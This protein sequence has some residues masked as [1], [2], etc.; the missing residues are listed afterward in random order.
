MSGC[1]SYFHC[2]SR[3]VEPWRIKEDPSRG[4][5][6][7]QT[8]SGSMAKTPVW[9]F[10]SCVLFSIVTA[11]AVRLRPVRKGATAQESPMGQSR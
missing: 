3:E 9:K 11:E 10:L 6:L 7:L 4:S 8:A 2:F 5:V 1:Q